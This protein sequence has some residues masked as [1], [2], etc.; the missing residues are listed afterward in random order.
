MRP[1]LETLNVPGL[2]FVEADRSRFWSSMRAIHEQYPDVRWLLFTH[3][4][5]EDIS[6]TQGLSIPLLVSQSGWAANCRIRVQLID[7][8]VL[9]AYEQQVI[10]A[11]SI[12]KDGLHFAIFSAKENDILSYS[13]SRDPQTLRLYESRSGITASIAG[14]KMK[15]K[16]AFFL[17]FGLILWGCSSPT[18]SNEVNTTQPILK[19]SVEAEPSSIIAD[20]NSRMV[21]FTEFLSDDLPIADSTRNHSSEYYRDLTIREDLYSCGSCIGYLAVGYF[22]QYGMGDCLRFRKTGFD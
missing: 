19:L 13:E 14:G 16:A 17:A 8:Q 1:P 10:D 20:G 9:L 11:R 6:R 15:V 3:V 5:R 2:P 4:E 21:I 22:R 18:T 7:L 12:R